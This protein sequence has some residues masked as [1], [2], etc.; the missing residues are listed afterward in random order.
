MRMGKR[1]GT[2]DTNAS[3]AYPLATSMLGSLRATTNEPTVTVTD[4]GPRAF[5]EIAAPPLSHKEATPMMS[6]DRF[7][8]SLGPERADRLLTVLEQIAAL[9]RAE[10]DRILDSYLDVMSP[11]EAP[12]PSSDPA[13][14]ARACAMLEALSC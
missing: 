12:R 4:Q 9:P 1:T 5:N 3:G 11:L 14:V 2:Q 6:Y 8:A 7:I 13:L 10:S